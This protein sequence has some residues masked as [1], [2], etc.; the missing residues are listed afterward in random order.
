MPASHEVVESKT[1]LT[2]AAMLNLFARLPHVA[3]S[4]QRG[5]KRLKLCETSVGACFENTLGN[6]L[7]VR[8]SGWRGSPQSGQ[9]II[10]SDSTRK[11]IPRGCSTEKQRLVHHSLGEG[12]NRPPRPASRPAK[13]FSKHALGRNHAIARA[14]LGNF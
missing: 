2:P 11:N 1:A 14:G 10:C 4:A 13:I 9:P 3:P 8:R 6:G 12:G 7:R 5:A